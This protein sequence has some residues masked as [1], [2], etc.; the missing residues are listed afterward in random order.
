MTDH[1]LPV[2]TFAGQ[3]DLPKTLQTM[4]DS[5]EIIAIQMFSDITDFGT[6]LKG[7][8]TPTLWMANGQGIHNTQDVEKHFECVNTQNIIKAVLYDLMCSTSWK[9]NPAA[10]CWN[11]NL[12]KTDFDE[13]ECFEVNVFL[14]KDD[15]AWVFAV[16][17]ESI[18]P[19]NDL[20]ADASYKPNLTLNELNADIGCDAPNLDSLG[21]IA[22]PQIGNVQGHNVVQIQKKMK[23]AIKIL[24]THENIL[25]HPT[26]IDRNP[27]TRLI[28]RFKA[29]VTRL[30][31]GVEIRKENETLF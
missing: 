5:D 12:S 7:P 24:K 8:F 10:R 22:L 26:E 14:F 11:P 29:E 16:D 15:I 27:A 18:Q 3:W 4:L 31:T 21:V 28:N 2:R 1:I 13:R 19:A 30:P 20:S 6:T 9:E 25:R 23:K 17:P